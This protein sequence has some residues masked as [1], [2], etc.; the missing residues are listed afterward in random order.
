M[1]AGSRFQFLD[2]IIIENQQPIL[3]TNHFSLLIALPL[4][5]Y[6]SHGKRFSGRHT[7]GSLVT[8]HCLLFSPG[9]PVS[10]SPNFTSKNV[11]FVM[12]QILDR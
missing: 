6:N 5:P 12:S 2:C 11:T 10:Q 7:N 1:E 8:S 4:P 9:L 3:I